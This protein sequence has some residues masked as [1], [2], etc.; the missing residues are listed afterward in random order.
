[1][2]TSQLSLSQHERCD[3]LNNEQ[4]STF[5]RSVIEDTAL[6]NM[7]ERQKATQRLTTKLSANDVTTPLSASPSFGG[8]DPSMPSIPTVERDTTV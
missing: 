3:N 2:P 1:M 4:Q 6:H 7:I 8:K 5:E